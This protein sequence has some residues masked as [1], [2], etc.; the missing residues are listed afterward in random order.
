MNAA[1]SSY[2]TYKQMQVKTADQGSLV[3][4]LYDGAILSLKHVQKVMNTKPLDRETLSEQTIKAK[5]IIY[6][7][8]ASLDLDAGGEIAKSLLDLYGYFIWRIGRADIE[9]DP[10]LLDDVLAH[11]QDLREAWATVFQNARVQQNAMP[12]AYIP[13]SAVASARPGSAII[14]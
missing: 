12:S 9:K 7:L 11:L 6:E 14:A 4:M 5:N 8:A 13:Q 3:L 2:G 10:I 1:S